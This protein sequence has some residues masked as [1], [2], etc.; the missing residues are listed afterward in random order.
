MSDMLVPA[1]EAEITREWLRAAL[2][3]SFPVATFESFTRERIGE[4][5]GF[6]SRLYRCRWREPGIE[7]SVVV[8]QWISLIRYLKYT[9]IR[10]TRPLMRRAVLIN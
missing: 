9:L 5:Y 2:T 4:S 1:F 6:A 8:K 3:A 10:L 7:Q